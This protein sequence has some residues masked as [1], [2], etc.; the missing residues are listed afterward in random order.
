MDATK[1]LIGMTTFITT[2]TLLTSS[3][4]ILDSSLLICSN[5]FCFPFLSHSDT[6]TVLQTLCQVPTDALSQCQ[7]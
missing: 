2:E 7:A 5:S 3:A 4:S 1:A 6:L